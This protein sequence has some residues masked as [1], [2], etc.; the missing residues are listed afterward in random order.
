M[1]TRMTESLTLFVPTIFEEWVTQTITD[2]Y[3]R[4]GGA[5]SMEGEGYYASPKGV[6]T[7]DRMTMI[8]S[9]FH[10]SLDVELP[11][12]IKEFVAEGVEHEESE[13]AYV[14]NGSM[15]IVDCEEEE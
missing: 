13:V 5:T 14:W 4:F 6:L 1:T 8:T 11:E 2:M 10:K 9:F 7:H 12:A 15:Y 3:L